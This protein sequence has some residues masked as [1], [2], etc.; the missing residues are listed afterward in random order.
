MLGFFLY[1]DISFCSFEVLF[2][3]LKIKDNNFELLGIDKIFILDDKV[4]WKR[5]GVIIGNYIKLFLKSFG[6]S[7]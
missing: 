6:L 2:K 1:R 4:I 7:S 3:F 5:L